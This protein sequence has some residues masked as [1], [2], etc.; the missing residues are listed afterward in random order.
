MQSSLS[1]QK[2]IAEQKAQELQI[3]QQLSC[4]EQKTKLL[5]ENR[6]AAAKILSQ[7]LSRLEANSS[8]PRITEV[9][10]RQS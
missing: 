5:A 6:K 10:S 3:A 1:E 4:F 9:K 8:T 2:Q 7:A